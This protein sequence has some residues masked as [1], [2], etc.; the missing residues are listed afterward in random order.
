MPKLTKLTEAEFNT[1]DEESCTEKGKGRKPTVKVYNGDVMVTVRGDIDDL[2]I[3]PGTYNSLVFVPCEL[4]GE[5]NWIRGFGSEYI[6]AVKNP[7]TNPTI[8][9]NGI[10]KPRTYRAGDYKIISL[11]N[12]GVLFAFV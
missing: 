5:F 11:E 10:R 12:S 1:R 8:A 2:V 7:A 3:A 6:I 4:V 9:T